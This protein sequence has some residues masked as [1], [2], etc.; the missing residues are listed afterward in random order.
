LSSNS[1]AIQYLYAAA[2]QCGELRQGASII[3]ATLNEIDGKIHQAVGDT[4]AF[5]TL[6]Q[7][8]AAVNS[9]LGSVEGAV[10][11]LQQQLG[12]AAA[13]LAAA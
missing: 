5:T 11:A 6:M 8:S 7:Y 4:Q 2:E 1:D 10:S 3:A 13:R 9:M 12:D